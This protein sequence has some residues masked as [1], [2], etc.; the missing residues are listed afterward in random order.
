[1]KKW[2]HQWI[3]ESKSCG[4]GELT[5]GARI[6]GN[7]MLGIKMFELFLLGSREKMIINLTVLQ[8]IHI[9]PH[10]KKRKM[11]CIINQILPL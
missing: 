8:N 11:R 9:L 4:V 6:T 2:Y 7:G 3:V 10:T 1:M 5:E